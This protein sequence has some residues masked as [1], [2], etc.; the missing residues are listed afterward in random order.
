[1]SSNGTAIRV[2]GLSKCFNVYDHPRDR[3][4]QMFM[5]RL[6][7]LTGHAVR[8]FYREFWA[9]HNVSFEVGKGET[10]GIIGQNGS[11]KSTLLQLITGTMTPTSGTIETHGRIGALLELGSG[12]NP[13]FTGRENVY[14]NGSLLGLSQA[15]IDH[16]FD[17]IVAFAEIGEHLEHPVKTYSSGMKL[18]LAF[19]VQVAVDAEVLIID[20]A[21][22]V[23]DAK[24][25]K[26]CFRRLEEIKARGT[27][28]LFV[29][30]STEQIR[31]FC[32]RGL[33]L[34]KG[35]PIFWGDARQ[36]TVKY[37]ASIFPEQTAPQISGVTQSVSHAEPPGAANGWLSV[38]PDES[39]TH[40]FGVG[41]ASL[42]WCKILGL[43]PPNMLS[44]GRDLR[45]RC[46]FSWDS[47]FLRTIVER[48]GHESNITIGITLSNKK[49]TYL[50]GCN[51][52]DAGLRIDCMNSQHCIVEFEVST[53][54][55]AQGDYFLGVAIA[56]G[57][58][59]NHTQLKWHDNLLQ[60]KYV[61]S[62]KKVFGTIAVDYTMTEI[63][64]EVTPV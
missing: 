10:V 60:I 31:S 58:L 57:S 25:Q 29:S 26:K 16:K 9:L 30:H 40:T 32:D 1:M 18:R 22:A 36:A 55:L 23:G 54:H 59:K 6:Q 53:P 11:G 20:E 51:G 43:D 34:D 35:K 50:F 42:N 61:E 49:G 44:G 56:L 45:I 41:G 63:D 4:K 37:L 13:E 3:L 12:F 27:T 46:D 52:F 19:A 15:E 17:Y 48:N 2:D 33:V 28:I 7:S 39:E 62:D 14:L 21:L 64:P 24:F 38:R 8:K 47:D 5:P